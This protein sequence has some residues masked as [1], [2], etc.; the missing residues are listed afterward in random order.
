MSKLKWKMIVFPG[1]ALAMIGGIFVQRL[2]FAAEVEEVAPYHAKVRAAVDAMPEQI[3]DWVSEEIEIPAAAVA[4][5][6]PNAIFGRRYVN[7]LTGRQV[8]LLVV[9]CRDARD[10]AGH[11]PP[12]C[13]PSSGWTEEDRAMMQFGSIGLD[14]PWA[15]YEFSRIAS[16]YN[17]Q[18]TVLNVMVLPDGRIVHTMD[19]VREQA[20]DYRSRFLGAGQIQ[21]V[22]SGDPTKQECESIVSEFMPEVAPLIATISGGAK[23]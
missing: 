3:G 2:S 22:F 4:L 5:L 1:L 10:M 20:A 8:D 19:A 11:Y 17:V 18:M 12:V 16:G 13:Y 15:R 21:F 14:A 9:H 6:K 7:S 23:P